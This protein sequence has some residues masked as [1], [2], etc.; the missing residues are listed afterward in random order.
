M[1]VP[2]E[3]IVATCMIHEEQLLK[4]LARNCIWGGGKRCNNPISSPQHHFFLQKLMK[5]VY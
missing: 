1:Q 4:L 3:E 5:L 2:I